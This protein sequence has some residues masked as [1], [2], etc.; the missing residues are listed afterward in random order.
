MC[1]TRVDV[2]VAVR[3]EEQSI[4][5]FLDRIAALQLPEDVDLRVI[6]VEDSST[7]GTRPL[8]RRLAGENPHV[9]YYTVAPGLG[10]GAAVVFGLSHSTADAMIMLDVDGSHPV[11]AIPEMIRGFLDGAQVVQCVRRTLANRKLYRRIG[12]ASYQRLAHLLTGV[13]PSEQN[14]FYRL[15]SA[16]VTRWLL[17]QP[18]YWHYLRFPLPRR[19]EGALRKVYVDTYERTLGESKYGFGRLVNLA[20]DGVVSQMS[21]W[22]AALLLASL[23]LITIVLANSRLWPVAALL[24]VGIGW[25]IRRC[26]GLRRPDMLRRLH[27]LESGNATAS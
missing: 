8:L 4:P 18:R 3:D 1:M 23:S 7:D 21:G 2:I 14:I 20:V 27:V 15:V 19:P 9:G 5:V 16:D 6:F 12:A 10:Q 17:Q 26:I 24:S 11:E 25:V 13:D 22:R